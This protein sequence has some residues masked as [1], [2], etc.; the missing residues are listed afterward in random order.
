MNVTLHGADPRSGHHSTSG[1]KVAFT[2]AHRGQAA[3][4]MRVSYDFDKPAIVHPLPGG[5]QPKARSIEP[6]RYVVMVQVDAA[7]L[8]GLPTKTI[9]SDVFVNGA[10]VLRAQGEIPVGQ[11]VA[12]DGVLFLL[13]VV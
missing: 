9:D 8:P 7:D 3:V 12:R 4:R 11:S 6:G 5:G 10:L 2:F 13:D 1:D